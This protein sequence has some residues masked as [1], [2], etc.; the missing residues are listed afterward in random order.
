MNTDESVY[1]HTVSTET[2]IAT[3]IVDAKEGRDIAIYN[4]PGAYLQTKIP[5]EKEIHMILRYDFVD[6]M[7]EVN[8]D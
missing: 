3:L 7:C 5:P 1:S 4:I 8:P 2:L 6:I